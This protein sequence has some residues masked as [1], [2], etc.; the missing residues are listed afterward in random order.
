MG[1]GPQFL[2]DCF[3]L[4]GDRVPQILVSFSGVREK[5]GGV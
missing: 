5:E 1:G 3:G 2:L 4:L